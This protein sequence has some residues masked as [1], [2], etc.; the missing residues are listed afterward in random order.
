[1]PKLSELLAKPKIKKI[2]EFGEIRVAPPREEAFTAF[3]PTELDVAKKTS[4]LSETQIREVV[5]AP[6]KS[7]EETVNVVSKFINPALIPFEILSLFKDVSI[8]KLA[9]REEVSFPKAILEGL[10]RS[11]EEQRRLAE[12][13]GFRQAVKKVAPFE[14][15]PTLAEIG[16]DISALIG[17]V[18][19]ARKIARPLKTKL[20]SETIKEVGVKAEKA[21]LPKGKVIIQE[22]AIKEAAKRSTVTREAERLI[23]AKRLKVKVPPERQIPFVEDIKPVERK[24]IE[25]IVSPLIP[26][27]VKPTIS[28]V[29]GLK[30]AE[31]Q[32]ITNEMRLLTLKLRAEAKGARIGER[33][34]R[35]EIR[36]QQQIKSETQ[37]LIRNI[38]SLAE[39]KVPPDFKDQI[40]A[41][42]ARFDLHFRTPKTLK[43]REGLR[44]FVERLKA[45]GELITIP[46]EQLENLD[47]V[48]LN[49]LTVED[50][51]QLRDTVAQIV[52]VGAL[53]RKLIAQ[54]EVRDFDKVVNDVTSQIQKTSGKKPTVLDT[55]FQAPSAT[56]KT[57]IQQKAN[58]VDAYFAEHR[59]VEFI[60]RTLDGFKEGSVQKNITQPIQD[61]GSNELRETEATYN[62]MRNSLKPIE[63]RLNDIINKV[64]KVG[65]LS[66]TEEEMLGVY[67]NSQNAGNLDRLIR[68]NNL[69]QKQVD[70]IIQAMPPDVKKFGD[71][72]FKLIDSKFDKTSDVT[73]KLTG[74]RPEKVKG[75]YFPIIV[76]RELSKT[77]ALRE[78]QRDLFQQV[79]ERTSVPRGFTKA[80][81]GGVDPVSLKALSSIV[82]HLDDVVHFNTHALPVRDVQKL[83]ADPRIRANITAMMGEN[84][85]NQFTPWIRDVANPRTLNITNTE[86]FASY[87]RRKSTLA[88]LGLNFSVS[89]LQ[90]GSFTLTINEIGTKAALGGL[91]DFWKNPS[92]ATEFIFSKSAQMQFRTRNFDREIRDVLRTNNIQQL[93]KGKPGGTDLLFAM[94]RGVDMLTTL[95]SWMGAYNKGMSLTGTEQAA[96][97]F[98]DRVVRRTQPQGSVKDLAQISRGRPWQKLW[99][100][101]YS[102]FSNYHNQMVSIMDRLKFSGNHPLRKVA[103]SAT[104]LFWVLI[105]PVV[106]ATVTRSGGEALKDPEKFRKAFAREIITYGFG[107]LFLGR[108]MARAIATKFGFKGPPGLRGFEELT[109]TITAKKLP[110][111]IKSGIGALGTFVGIPVR[112]LTITT[113]GLLDLMTGQSSDLRRLFLSK[114]AIG[115]KKTGGFPTL[116]KLPKLPKLS[117]LR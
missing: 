44:N 7:L 75:K 98:A 100:M 84:V 104:G 20:L 87:L 25:Q 38:N 26:S 24:A 21:G 105:A 40:D 68:G 110:T 108:D 115:E 76:D 43:K 14:I 64:R 55:V 77:A 35:A 103:N 61:A 56:N 41:E 33:V 94:I 23:K 82:K 3:R 10:T 72:M 16:V 93:M 74:Q 18:T 69:T 47:K 70:K 90:G 37:R 5:G 65:D 51:K 106:I 13:P 88:T 107:G 99:T 29:T 58:S 42:L 97:Q 101:F 54:K 50:L 117:K 112:Q 57:F 1:M 66:L 85:T 62:S 22:E 79:F 59:K 8:R 36:E 49:D 80:R 96:V 71:D 53:K 67:L 92:K 116:P 111:K 19:A 73:A 27:K 91:I 15:A 34:G 114:F 17:G 12:L 2:S 109:K 48:T 78:T 9:G 81:V 31:N 83:I 86:K 45:E 30:K 39:R 28:R 102:H 32:I 6:R 52:H 113:Q 63:R 95:P 46:S 4:G 11:P 60:S 89:L